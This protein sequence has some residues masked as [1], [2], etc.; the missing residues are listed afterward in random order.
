LKEASNLINFGETVC[1]AKNRIAGAQKK[2]ASY[3]C[4]D[5]RPAPELSKTPSNKKTFLSGRITVDARK[6]D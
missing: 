1:L 4:S 6:K 2:L 3:F 5:N